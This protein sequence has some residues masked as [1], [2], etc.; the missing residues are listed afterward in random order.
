MRKQGGAGL[1]SKR[2]AGE[3]AGRE[4]GEP[5]LAVEQQRG[6]AVGE[7]MGDP[8][9]LQQRVDPHMDEAGAGGR[10][11]QQAASRFLG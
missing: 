7:E 3:V 11:R 4:R 6:A 9:P 1:S 5:G 10:Q 8:Q 2:F